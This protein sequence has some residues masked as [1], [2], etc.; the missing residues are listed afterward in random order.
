MQ[1]FLI[2]IGQIFGFDWSNAMSLIKNWVD[3]SLF[4][5]SNLYQLIIFMALVAI[6]KISSIPVRKRLVDFSKKLDGKWYQHIVT[7]VQSISTSFIVILFLILVMSVAKGLGLSV[8]MFSIALNLM[9]VWIII[10]F[11]SSFVNNRRLARSIAIVAFSVAALNMLGLLSPA[12]KQLDEVVFNIGE[13][14]FSLLTVIKGVASFFAIIW[15][16]NNF[17]RFS[18]KRIN[19]MTSITPSLR[20]LIIKFTRT[21]LI[22]IAFVIALDTLGINLTSLAVFSGA[23][24][25]GLGFGLQKVVSNFIS[26]IILLLDRSI[27]PGDVIA[28]DDTY[29]WVNRLGARCVSVITRDGKEH[30]IPNEQFITEKVENWSYSDKNI[31]LKINI[32][33]SYSSDVRKALELMQ[34]VARDSSRILKYPVPMALLKGFGDSSVNLELRAWID[35]PANGTSNISSELMLAIWDSFHENDIK[36]PFPQRDIH[37]RTNMATDDVLD[38]AS[39]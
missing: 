37:I 12:L 7:A 35:D 1:E 26:G 34:S 36:F 9:A 38:N 30:L 13:S 31:R 5:M 2:N 6:A 28:L 4:S 16:A 39:N 29:G 14:S 15:F 32:G 23:V 10:R 11:S 24:G 27:K 18:E 33:I 8:N 20:V 21:L 3:D 19:S 22:I 25:V 17:V